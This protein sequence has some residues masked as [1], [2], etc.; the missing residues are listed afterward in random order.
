M[1]HGLKG[2]ELNRPAEWRKR[3]LRSMM[4]S[5]LR[6]ERITVTE[7]RAK[8]LRRHIEKLVT[9]ARRGDVHSRRLCMATLPDPPAI[10]KLFEL[11][12]P[13]YKERP[14]GY[15]RITRIGLR[16]GDGATMAQIEFVEATEPV[17]AAA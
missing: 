4:G 12:A 14:G 1:R 5:L 6:Y 9:V 11:V 17:S 3:M 15:T 16:K 10:S 13:R 7:A 8:E 2:R